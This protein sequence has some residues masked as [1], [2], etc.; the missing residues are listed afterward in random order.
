MDQAVTLG[1]VLGIF[2]WLAL[3]ALVFG[4][5]IFILWFMAQGWDH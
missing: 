4:V 1:M 5:V 3:I 2:G